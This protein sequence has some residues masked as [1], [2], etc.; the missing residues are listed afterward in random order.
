MAQAHK[1]IV[2][3][4]ALRHEAMRAFAAVRKQL[5]ALG[6]QAAEAGQI[7]SAESVFEMTM[8]ETA[9]LDVGTVP[10]AGLFAERAAAREVL[11]AYDMPDLL[12]RFDDLDAY[13]PDFDADATRL[14]GMSLVDGVVQG[15]AWVLNEPSMALPEGFDPAETVLIARSVDSGWIPTFTK[16][17]AVVVEMGGDLSHGSIILRELQI[18]SATN[19]KTAT[20]VFS[21]GDTVEIN[22]GTGVVKK[23]T[24]AE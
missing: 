18:P 4:E 16:V 8:A 23:V 1:L 3:R 12:H 19:V 15:K 11:A 20:R 2:A 7:P 10:E 14:K 6:A 13:A 5:L 22:G 9:L 24:S 21:T 17:A